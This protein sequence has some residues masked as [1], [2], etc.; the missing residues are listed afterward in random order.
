MSKELLDDIGR[1]DEYQHTAAKKYSLSM[2]NT[3]EENYQENA[4]F[5]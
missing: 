3:P 5:A 1:E 2:E 4:N